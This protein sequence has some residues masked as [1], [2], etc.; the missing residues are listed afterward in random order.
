[1]LLTALQS[2]QLSDAHNRAKRADT[3]D[4]YTR[5]ETNNVSLFL[6]RSFIVRHLA[7]ANLSL[8]GTITP[9]PYQT[10]ILLVD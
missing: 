7:G 9:S 4:L 1:M 10:V 2:G 3:N 5:L 6:I 8:E